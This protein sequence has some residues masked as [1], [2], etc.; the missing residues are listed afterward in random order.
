MTYP[1]FVGFIPPPPFDP[2]S[3]CQLDKST[4]LILGK[5]WLAKLFISLAIY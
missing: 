4:F 2:H 5:K 3:I 1:D